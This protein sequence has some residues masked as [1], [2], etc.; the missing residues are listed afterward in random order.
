[1]FMSW[2]D[3]GGCL[4]GLANLEGKRWPLEW[5][6]WMHWEVLLIAIVACSNIDLFYYRL[7]VFGL[8]I[9]L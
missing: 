8:I 2:S 9:F 5:E 1:M 6:G 3:A 4:D 7:I